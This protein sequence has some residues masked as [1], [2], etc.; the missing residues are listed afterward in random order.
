MSL[1]GLER[2]EQAD[3]FGRIK[4]GETEDD[5]MLTSMISLYR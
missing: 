4:R 2:A 1:D 5:A 3:G